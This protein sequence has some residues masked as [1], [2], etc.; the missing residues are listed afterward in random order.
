MSLEP[1]PNCESCDRDLPPDSREACICSFECTWCL[2]CAATRLDFIRANC[3]GKLVP[4]PLRP[5]AWL[6]KRP[7]STVRVRGPA[8]CVSRDATEPRVGAPLFTL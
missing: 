1:R 4:G 7:A 8:P 6:A 5:A 3:G 2:D